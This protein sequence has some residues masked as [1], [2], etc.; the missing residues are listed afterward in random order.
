MARLERREMS[1]GYRTCVP[2]LC[3]GNCPRE[4]MFNLGLLNRNRKRIASERYRICE[5]RDKSPRDLER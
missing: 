1:F 3:L 4:P 2:A 5:S